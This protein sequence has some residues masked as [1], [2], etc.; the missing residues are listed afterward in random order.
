MVVLLAKNMQRMCLDTLQIRL[1]ETEIRAQEAS[2]LNYNIQD[3]RY[4]GLVRLIRQQWSCHSAWLSRAVWL[5]AALCIF[6]PMLMVKMHTSGLVKPAAWYRLMYRLL[7]CL[8]VDP[9]NN[10][11]SYTDNKKISPWGWRGRKKKK[12]QDSGEVFFNADELL[13]THYL[14]QNYSLHHLFTLR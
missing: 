13:V 11:R 14:D 9:N 12:K 2:Q 4:P 1:K 7:I 5:T 8:L 3:P 10:Y 6:H